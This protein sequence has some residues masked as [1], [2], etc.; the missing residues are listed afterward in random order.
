MNGIWNKLVDLHH[1]YDIDLVKLCQ[2][3]EPLADLKPHELR[4]FL[5][6]IVPRTYQN[7][8]IIFELGKPAAATFLVLSGSVGFY[9]N[10]RIPMERTKYVK[11]GE[12]FG[13]EALLGIEL[14]SRTA[15][16][17]E[18]TK[19]IA[20]TA[21]DFKKLAQKSPQI[22]NKIWRVIAYGLFIQLCT[23]EDELQTLTSRLTKANIIV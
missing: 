10:H 9:Q 21:L 4:L 1:K 18:E 6:F 14:R 23:T 22:A 12:W 13:E 7:D 2:D 8:E 15:R 5:R 19:V 11:R 3:L 20:V 16:A 17:Q